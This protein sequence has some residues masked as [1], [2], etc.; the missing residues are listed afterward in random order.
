MEGDSR[1]GSKRSLDA[2]PPAAAVE[3]RR[4]RASA[5]GGYVP[6]QPIE[7]PESWKKH[8]HTMQEVVWTTVSTCQYDDPEKKERLCTAVMDALSGQKTLK[9]PFTTVQ[10]YFHRSREGMVKAMLALNERDNELPNQIQVP[11]P[12]TIAKYEEQSAETPEHNGGKKGEKLNSVLGLLTAKME[13]RANSEENSPSPDSYTP[14]GSNKRKP[15]S[16]HRVVS[17]PVTDGDEG[18]FADSLCESP[19]FATSEQALHYGP[20]NAAVEQGSEATDDIFDSSEEFMEDDQV[21]RIMQT[22]VSRS[23]VGNDTKMRLMRAIVRVWKGALTPSEACERYCLTSDYLGAY[24]GLFREAMR[25]VQQTATALDG[26]GDSSIGVVVTPSEES[27]ESLGGKAMKASEVKKGAEKESYMVGPPLDPND[28]KRM[29]A[30]DRC[31]EDVCKPSLYSSEQ[32]EKLHKAILMVVRGECTVNAAANVMQLPSSTLHPYVHKARTSLGLL[33]PPQASGPT[34]W[35]SN[36]KLHETADQLNTVTEGGEEANENTSI[37]LEEID[38]VLTELLK[39][40]NCDESGKNK[41]YQATLMVLAENVST[42]EAAKRCGV[43]ASTIQP[44]VTKARSCLEQSAVALTRIKKP[45]V[46]VKDRNGLPTEVA[47]DEEVKSVVEKLLSSC[48]ARNTRREKLLSAVSSAVSGKLTI[49]DACQ[50]EGLP[51][52]TVHPYVSKARHMLGARCPEPKVMNS[53]QAV[54]AHGSSSPVMGDVRI[55]TVK[56]EDTDNLQAAGSSGRIVRRLVMNRTRPEMSAEIEKILH[57]R[58]Y[59]GV[60]RNLREALLG[61]L[62]DQTDA[63]KLCSQ[64]HVAMTT[65][66]NYLKVIKKKVKTKVDKRHT[67]MEHSA[68]DT[69]LKKSRTTSFDEEVGDSSEEVYEGSIRRSSQLPNSA[70]V[71]DSA[72]QISGELTEGKVE[73]KSTYQGRVNSSTV[74]PVHKR[75]RTQRVNNGDAATEESGAGASR[76]PSNVGAMDLHDEGA[77]ACKQR[78]IKLLISYIV[79]RQYQRSAKEQQLL[80]DSLEHVLLDGLLVEEAN[81]GLSECVLRAYVKRCKE[82]NRCIMSEFPVFKAEIREISKKV[83]L[84]SP[85]KQ[86][87]SSTSIR[88]DGPGTNQMAEDHPVTT[89]SLNSI[90]S[91]QVGASLDSYIRKLKL[92]NFPICTD[93]I[94]G[95]A[96]YTL[97]MLNGVYKVP[98]QQWKEWAQMY[99]KD[100]GYVLDSDI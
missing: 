96:E 27:N 34:L 59:K 40:S 18:T 52:S 3:K 80:C 54:V 21:R 16:V 35:I 12:L 50:L 39:G 55:V 71:S 51:A 8:P 17:E 62:F 11:V 82:V 15:K 5:A 84:L 85:E 70:I 58:G 38:E 92:A 30:I 95:L 53:P 37:N 24:F 29:E 64:H 65:L 45:E 99:C 6:F 69:S 13:Q 90:F 93:L 32:K 44:Y 20:S 97:L 22:C 56:D 87:K 19:C 25:S 88:T 57:Q 75:G 1:R 49:K 83:S 94:I 46:L 100:H 47:S 78:R 36:K 10:T 2:Q 41:I 91:G 74:T 23:L 86:C 81:E 76:L 67:V 33:L 79:C 26:V 61:A 72:E 7:I 60:G 77:L 28:K 4:K 68:L 42:A 9:V 48:S 66:T 98:Q 43:S 31:V 14:S 63:S 73:G 89:A